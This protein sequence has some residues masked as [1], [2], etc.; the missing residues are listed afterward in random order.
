MQTNIR[1]RLPLSHLFFI[2]ILSGSAAQRGLCP[3]R[4]QG[5]LITQRR[6]TLSRTPLD[7]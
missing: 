6:A 4:S 3:P 1:F 2:F 5:F 7:E